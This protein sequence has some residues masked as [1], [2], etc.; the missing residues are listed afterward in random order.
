MLPHKWNMKQVLRNNCS[1]KL[2][3][4]L[5]NA[6]RWR[7]PSKSVNLKFSRLCPSF[8]FVYVIL[9]ISLAPILLRKINMER[10]KFNPSNFFPGCWMN[11]TRASK[12]FG[13][14]LSTSSKTNRALSQRPT[15]LNMSSLRVSYFDDAHIADVSIDNR[16]LHIIV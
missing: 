5:L 15:V 12:T 7:L 14:V 4:L 3:P 16:K 6:S 11:G 2:L 10:L 9:V 13:G 1:I 8:Q